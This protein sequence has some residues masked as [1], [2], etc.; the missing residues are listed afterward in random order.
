MSSF[1]SCGKTESSP[2]GLADE[3]THTHDLASIDGAMGLLEIADLVVLRL[4][5]DLDAATSG[6]RS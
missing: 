3:A 2:P 4:P 6:K 1:T 5:H